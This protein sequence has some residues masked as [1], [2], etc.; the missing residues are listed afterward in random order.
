MQAGIVRATFLINE[1]LF[2]LL[3][4]SKDMWGSHK[5][6]PCL[7]SALNMCF[8]K[9]LYELLIEK[10][11]NFKISFKRLANLKKNPEKLNDCCARKSSQQE[12]MLVKC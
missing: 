12:A 9:G 3:K 2:D 7:T 5:K 8:I 1:G 4:I 6:R 11:Q 10:F